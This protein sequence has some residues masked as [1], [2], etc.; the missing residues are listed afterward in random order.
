[1]Q[2]LKRAIGYAIGGAIVGAVIGVIAH[3]SAYFI[4]DFLFDISISSILSS[5]GI[6]DPLPLRKLV[7]ILSIGFAVYGFIQSF[8]NDK[9][10]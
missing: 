10:P 2:A 8:I 6:D 9:L 7:S 4:F 1:M 5:T 3:Y